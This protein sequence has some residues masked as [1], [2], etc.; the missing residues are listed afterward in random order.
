MPPKHTNKACLR[1]CHGSNR[2]N[3]L[4]LMSSVTIQNTLEVSHDCLLPPM[5]YP[6]A[7]S[8]QV[9]AHGNIYFLCSFNSIPVPFCGLQTRRDKC[10]EN[11]CVSSS[12]RSDI[13]KQSVRLFD[14][15]DSAVCH[16]AREHFVD[17][18]QTE[19]RV[20]MKNGS[21]STRQKPQQAPFS[22]PQ[23]LTHQLDNI[24]I[25]L[26]YTPRASNLLPLFALDQTVNQGAFFFLFLS[27]FSI[28]HKSKRCT[29]SVQL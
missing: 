19:L 2:A 29:H 11:R 6:V 16:S 10:S 3:G 5:P 22:I 1:R 27:L 24:Y 28:F 12:P 9:N 15:S 14:V 7:F 13:L 8:V 26:Q 18:N 23:A 17:A 25:T 20:I 4:C 21:Q